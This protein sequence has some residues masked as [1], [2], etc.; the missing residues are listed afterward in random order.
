MVITE[1]YY[2]ILEVDPTAGR[3]L[4]VRSYKRLA[5]KLHPDHNRR[6]DATEAFQRVSNICISKRSSCSKVDWKLMYC[7]LCGRMRHYST[8]R[9]AARTTSSTLPSKHNEHLLKTRNAH[10]RLQLHHRRQKQ[11]AK[12]RRSPRFQGQ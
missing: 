8:R 10:V 5:L 9:N 4:I 12:Q 3:E 6:S 11:P 2:T 7:S 1:D